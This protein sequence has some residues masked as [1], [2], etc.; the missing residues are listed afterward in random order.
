MLIIE[1]TCLTILVFIH[2]LG[3][4]IEMRRQGV[5]IAEFGIG[6]P[7]G[8]NL[9][10]F[11]KPLNMRLAFSL[12]LLG[13]YVEPT[14]KGAQIMETM[15]HENRAMIYGAGPWANL[16]GA[17]VLL[18][19]SYIVSDNMPSALGWSILATTTLIAI[20]RRHF[21]LYLTPVLGW[22]FLLYLLY[23]IGYGYM[24]NIPGSDTLGG[25]VSVV[26][27]IT[28]QHTFADLLKISSLISLSVCIFNCLPLSA[29]DGGRIWISLL[30]EKSFYRLAKY[31]QIGGNILLGSIIALAIFNDLVSLIF[32]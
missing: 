2:E 11:I 28:K 25:P 20:F 31:S 8:P 26:K 5:E 13:A 4:A 14:T 12:I 10:F 3:H 23:S 7:L 27:I 15:P 21:S 16:V 18:E 19:A 6:L 1:I 24:H 29:L 9:N 30:K 32:K 22:I 17:I